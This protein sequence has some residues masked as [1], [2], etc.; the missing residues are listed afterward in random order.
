MHDINTLT[1]Y[2]M[3]TFHTIVRSLALSFLLYKACSFMH[4]NYET[5]F[6]R[7]SLTEL[8]CVS[9]PNICCEINNG[10]C[11]S[12]FFQTHVQ[13]RTLHTIWHFHRTRERT[14]TPEELITV[15]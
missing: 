8:H 15:L 6:K 12:H 4:I 11:C 5:W 2:F 7:F 14:S 13:L 3:P 9:S 10:G 1:I